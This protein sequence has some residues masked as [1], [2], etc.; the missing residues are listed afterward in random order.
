MHE[1]SLIMLGAGNSTRFSLPV[2]KQWI[3]IAN[4]PLWLFATK[5]LC[6]FYPFKKVVV[7]SNE[8]EY[9]RKFAPNFDFVKGGETRQ[10]SLKNALE[11]INSDYV[12]VSDIA[13]PCISK[14]LF[15]RILDAIHNADCVVPILKT[16]DT[17]YY[18]NNLINRDSLKLIQTPQLSKTSIL[19]SA[20]T[21]SNF[22]TDDSSAIKAQNGKIWYVKGSKMANKITYYDD[23]LDLNLPKP[24]QEIFSGNGFDLHK[25]GANRDLIICGEKIPYEMG[26]IAHSDG[27]V[28]IHALIDAM[29]GACALGDI[30][31]FYPDNDDKFKNIDSRILLK[32]SAEKIK[33]I[34]FDIVNLD[35][36][37]I[38]QEP[39]ISPFKD[40][41]CE[42]LSK[43]LQLPQ[44]FINVKASTTEKLGVIGQK[45][46]IA[47]IANVNL[48]Y[49]D[50]TKC[51]S[52]NN[53]K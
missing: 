17:A 6:N 2:K 39:K 5:N 32:N 45:E 27:D 33:S 22:Y 10:D 31:T 37:I 34:G 47:A 13:R 26:L 30:G 14:D 44:N 42:N 20:L 49:Y 16:N 9:M 40:K 43:I 3:R 7:V 24:S 50:W 8:C 53:K 41:M 1:I 4:E 29:F 12:L 36:T 18:E 23:L 38:A 35:I 19:K 52:F 48:R 28:G 11:N 46:G 51:K 15:S 21:S 25:F